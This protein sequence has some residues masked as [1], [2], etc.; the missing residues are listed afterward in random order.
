MSSKDH[1]AQDILRRIYTVLPDTGNMIQLHAP[2]MNGNE[3][4]YVAK[5]IDDNWV[6]SA[7]AFI[8]DFEKA[9]AKYCGV[10]HAVAVTNGTVALHIALVACG[11]KP[12]EEV[13]V[14][15][16]T[17]VATA[18]A[19]SH[20]NAICHF[21][22]CE[23]KTLGVDPDKLRRH[24]SDICTVKDGKTINKKTGRAI[25]AI[26]PVHIFGVPADIDRICDVANEF[27]LQV[28]Q[29]CAESLGSTFHGQS[30][31]GLGR[32]ACTSFNGN[33]IITAGG[34]GALLTDDD[35]LAS[36]FKH[37]TTTAK[38]PHPYLFHH[39]MVGYNYRMPNL[40]AALVMAQLEQLPDFLVRK[41]KLA[42]AYQNAFA[43]FQYGEFLTYDDRRQPNYWL[44]AL[45]VDTSS[46]NDLE[47]MLKFL[48]NNNVQA[49]PIWTPMHQLP[50]YKDFYRGD[51]SVTEK[52]VMQIINLPSSAFL[53]P[54]QGGI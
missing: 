23:T 2:F 40:N 14:P 19:V 11:I 51:L 6:S 32:C 15:S 21:V 18:N 48:N 10:K 28:I 8:T 34:G 20:A 3:K 17:F 33:K 39:D 22:D 16:L 37:L 47:D 30:F 54:V 35:D 12:G 7:G 31:F 46:Q 41:K 4:E 29:D 27:K 25:A 13:I 52:T 24:L 36:L 38:R 49:R 53:E 45:R 1:I 26:M 50:M 42:M 44:N 5:T 43:D 9:L